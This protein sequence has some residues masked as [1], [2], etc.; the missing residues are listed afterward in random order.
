MTRKEEESSG[1]WG[2]VIEQ[3][4]RKP[5]RKVLIALL[6]HHSVEVDEETS[7]DDKHIIVVDE[8]SIPKENNRHVRELR[9]IPANLRAVMN[10]LGY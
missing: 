10:Y 9:K 6:K 8:Y 5:P 2:E 1:L 7:E 3:Y 4:G